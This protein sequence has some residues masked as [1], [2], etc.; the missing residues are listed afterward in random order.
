MY[1]WPLAPGSATRFLTPLSRGFFTC[2]FWK[3]GELL[4]V[5]ENRNKNSTDPERDS[6]V[7][8]RLFLIPGPPSATLFLYSAPLA[9]FHLLGHS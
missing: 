3:L 9:P 8:D 2:S 1:L 7:Y 6:W 5:V 4:G